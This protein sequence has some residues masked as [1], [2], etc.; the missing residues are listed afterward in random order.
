[1]YATFP[2]FAR[3]VNQK[4]LMFYSSFSW[5][6]EPRSQVAVLVQW[7]SS[8][9]LVPPFSPSLVSPCYSWSITMLRQVPHRLLHHSQR[10][11]SATHLH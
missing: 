6:S 2:E 7:S 4:E 3:F 1:M 10:E 5:F 8:L 11:G 9:S